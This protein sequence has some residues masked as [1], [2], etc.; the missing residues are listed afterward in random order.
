MIEAVEQSQ[1]HQMDA[2]GSR[3]MDMM[4]I[5]ESNSFYQSFRSKTTL[6]LEVGSLV[7]GG[8][9]AVKGVIGFTRLA[10]TPAKITKFS[11]QLKWP[12]PVRGRS[13]VNGIEYTTHALERM[14]P[15]GLIQNGTEIISRGVPPSVVENAINFGTKT[16]ANTS[17][18]IVHVF[19]NV[20]VVTTLDSTKVITVIT[21]GRK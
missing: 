3:L 16:L 9:G 10:K 13:V 5:D 8:Y 15:R 12:S 14:A 20:R 18:E 19:E 17:Q 7:A 6:G 11:G 2:L 4:A 1:M 21:T